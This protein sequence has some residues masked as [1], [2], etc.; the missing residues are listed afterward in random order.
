[1]SAPG[2]IAGLVR[3]FG[4]GAGIGNFTLGANGV[5]AFAF[6]NGFGL[7][8]E[9]AGSALNVEMTVPASPS[10]AVRILTYAHPSARRDGLTV[11]AGYLAN[12][13]KAVFV[14]QIAERDATLPAVQSAFAGLWALAQSFGGPQ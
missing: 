7:R 14:A 6:E 2:W 1:M 4:A 12:A 10:S 13:G 11:R 8:F 9:Y 5:A 3:D